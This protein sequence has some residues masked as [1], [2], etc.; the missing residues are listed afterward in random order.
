MPTPQEIVDLVNTQESETSDLRDRM[1]SDYA[2]YRLDEWK[3]HDDLD[4][5]ETFTS[6]SPGTYG[7]KMIATVAAAIRIVHVMQAGLDKERRKINNAKEHFVLGIL[8]AGDE[9]LLRMMMARVQDQFAFYICIRGW[10]AGIAVLQ[11]TKG[12]HEPPIVNITPWDPRNTY[13]TKGK[14]GIDEAVHVTTMTR[15]QIK[16]TFGKELKSEPDSVGDEL[17]IKVYDWWDATHN[18]IATASVTLK[19]MTRHGSPR[20]PVIIGAVGATPLV[21]DDKADDKMKDVGESIYKNARRTFDDENLNGSILKEFGIRSMKR[22]YVITSKDGSK[23]LAEDPFL[24]NQETSLAEGDTLQPLEPYTVAQEMG[25]HLTS[26]NSQLARSTL[27]PAA[28]GE[29]PFQGSGFLFNSQVGQISDRVLFPMRALNDAVEQSVGLIVDQYADGAFAAMELSGRDQTP[30]RT[31]FRETITPEV[32][33]QGGEVEIRHLPTLPKDDAQRMAL[34]QMLRDP[35]AGLPLVDDR[36]VLEDLGY[37][38]ADQIQS[39]VVSQQALRSSPVST[40]FRFMQANMEE[41]DADQT[42]IWMFEFIKAYLAS[43]LQLQQLQF[44]GAQVPG[45]A[46]GQNGA[47]P[48][49]GGGGSSAGPTLLPASVVPSQQQGVPQAPPTI[50]A[51][52]GALSNAG[53]ARPGARSGLVGPNGQPL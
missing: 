23:T 12:T 35:S 42:Q 11:K 36:T 29:T 38:N 17:G 47:G 37:Q 48:G 24:S 13:W 20:I 6:N 15:A 40:A 32:V 46:G 50:Q 26:V 43:V 18:K 53:N 51:L 4:G 10:Y 25:V 39:A 9:R 52:I 33:K 28:Y 41:G 19:P 8:K 14:D 31:Y 21:W 3:G 1:D 7:D 16:R 27:P 45:G 30:Q 22:S 49:G 34:A 2:L 44:A 5:F